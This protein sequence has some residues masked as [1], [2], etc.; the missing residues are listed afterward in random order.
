MDAFDVSLLVSSTA[1][2]VFDFATVEEEELYDIV[3]PL[4]LTCIA[5]CTIHG[6][7]CWFDVLFPG[8]TRP[9]WLTTAPGQ[10]TTHWSVISN[11]NL[12][13]I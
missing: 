3:V 10:P 12:T 11:S 4:Q 7:A 8:S 13:A 1:T 9:V 2:K 6:L 5:P